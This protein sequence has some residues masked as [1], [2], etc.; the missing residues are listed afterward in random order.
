MNIFLEGIILI[1]TARK[2][3]TVI[4]PTINIAKD[5]KYKLPAIYVFSDDTIRIDAS[6]MTGTEYEPSKRQ[7]LTLILMI[8]FDISLRNFSSFER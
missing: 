8:R 2:I 5:T 4:T 6:L 7:F 3:R 1:T